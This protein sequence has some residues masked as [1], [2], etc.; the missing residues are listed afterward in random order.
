MGQ[1]EE[2]RRDYLEAREMD[3][4]ERSK[5]AGLTK[6]VPSKMLPNREQITKM[7]DEMARGARKF[8]EAAGQKKSFVNAKSVK[9]NMQRTLKQRRE[10]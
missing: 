5:L 6:N 2:A 4:R 10:Q 1:A 9:K 8:A 3:E 7:R